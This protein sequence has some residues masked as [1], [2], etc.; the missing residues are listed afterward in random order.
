MGESVRLRVLV[1]RGI[2]Y[3]PSLGRG[4][5]D[6][7]SFP[8]STG[9]VTSE[10]NPPSALWMCGKV[11]EKKKALRR[12]IWWTLGALGE[13]KAK[14]L[15]RT[16]L[17]P[18]T[19]QS[20][21]STVALRRSSIQSAQKMSGVDCEAGKGVSPREEKRCRA[22]WDAVCGHIVFRP[23]LNQNILPLLLKGQ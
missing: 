10:S 20:S 9:L 2:S 4:H 21:T 11:G 6:L 23:F 16:I 14:R 1:F 15:Y 13:E 22:G 19:L 18:L 7:S 3:F 8:S 17:G 12:G 5:G